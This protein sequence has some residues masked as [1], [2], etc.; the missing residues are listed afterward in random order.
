[1]HLTCLSA[2]LGE[3]RLTCQSWVCAS[4]VRMQA[5]WVSQALL[6][7]WHAAVEASN[8]SVFGDA[9]AMHQGREPHTTEG[10]C[11]P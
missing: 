4:K 10:K 2:G 3:R 5:C 11:C 6:Q 8:I 7:W 1:M 9:F